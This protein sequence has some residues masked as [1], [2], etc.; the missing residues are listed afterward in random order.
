MSAADR[1]DLISEFIDKAKINW[2][3]ISIAQMMKG[4]FIDRVLTTNFDPLVMRACAVVNLFPAVYDMAVVREGFLAD[5]VRDRAVFHLHGQRDGFVQLHQEPEVRALA[6]AI[7]PLFDDTTRDRTW[8]VIGY[9]GANDPVFQVLA[10][11]PRFPNRLFWVGYRGEKPTA[12][13]SS[14]LLEADKDAFWLSGYD[15]DNFLVQLAA[16]LG[17]F[18]PGFFTRPFTHL[19]EGYSRLA[20]FRLPGQEADLD[21]AARA[22]TWIQGAIVQFEQAAVASASTTPPPAAAAPTLGAMHVPPAPSY[23]SMPPSPERA[24]QPQPSGNDLSAATPLEPFSSTGD[25]ISAAWA[26][27]ITGD[28]EA[29]VAM[30]GGADADPP[31]ELAE[32]AAGA[33]FGRGKKLT[34]QASSARGEEADRLFNEAEASFARALAIKPND[35]ATLSNWGNAL[36][37][38]GRQK[39][40]SEAERL[41]ALAEKKLLDAEGVDAGVAA[42]RL[43]R[44]AAQ[45]G[46][47]D[48]SRRWLTVAKDEDMLPSRAYLESDPELKP[49]RSTS[50]FA[51]LLNEIEPASVSS[52]PGLR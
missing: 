24:L 20:G 41:F 51:A 9:S 21:W 23:G 12:A 49:I 38:W 39:A 46:R 25:E 7:E 50:W 37:R 13:V 26:A 28:Y 43:S 4:G 8:L 3:H 15:A 16:K 36:Y 27:L 22:R 11:R 42:Y 6:K 31:T 10:R 47:D 30:S 29:V 1:H 19:L 35:G 32:P 33:L 34:K 45:R 2:A 5:F 40:G 17:C 14:A 44:L 52:Q 18:P 48:E